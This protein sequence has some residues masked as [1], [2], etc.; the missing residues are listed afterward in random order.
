MTEAKKDYYSILAIHGGGMRGVIP[1]IVIQEIEKLTNKKIWELFDM[2]AGTSTGGIVSALATNEL[3]PYSGDEI[4][5]FYYRD[6]AEIFKTGLRNWLSLG[7]IAGSKYS[8][9]NLIECLQKYLGESKVGGSKTKFMVASYDKLSWSPTFIKSYDGKWDNVPT[10]QAAVATSS[11]PTY[12]PSLMIEN[13][14]KKYDLMD[15]GIY[16]NNPAMCALADG[17]RFWN[18]PKIR[19]VSLG[20]GQGERKSLPNGGLA[21]WAAQLLNVVFDGVLG[22]VDYQGRQVLNNNYYVFQ[23]ELKTASALDD[24]SKKTLDSLKF[25]TLEYIKNYDNK[26]R[27]EDLCEKLAN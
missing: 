16:A 23:P 14:G 10:W 7:G 12:F 27:L 6:G 5:E 15:G 8:S 25:E 1:S 21:T 24:A 9:K 22:T 18:T 4:V 2:V 17:F 13:E 11:A 20:T 26:K 3:K 19:V